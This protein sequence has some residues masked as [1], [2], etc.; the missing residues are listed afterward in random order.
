M[1][2]ES[3]K[4]IWIVRKIK[5]NCYFKFGADFYWGPGVACMSALPW[6]MQYP[7]ALDTHLLYILTSPW[8]MDTPSAGQKNA[9]SKILCQK[10]KKEEKAR[11]LM[12]NLGINIFFSLHQNAG[13]GFLGQ[14]EGDQSK[15]DTI[16]P[17]PNKNESR[18]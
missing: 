3:R 6:S 17:Y 12:Q 11:K 4:Q 10:L 7:L 9:F 8:V 15:E 1:L 5:K 13:F 18:N 16:N 2:H 14:R